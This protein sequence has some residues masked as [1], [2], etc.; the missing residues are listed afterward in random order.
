MS[1]FRRQIEAIEEAPNTRVLSVGRV[2][3][4]GWR[5]FWPLAYWQAARIQHQLLE[6]LQRMHIEALYPKR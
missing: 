2:R 4:T 6:E 3:P 1:D 5:R